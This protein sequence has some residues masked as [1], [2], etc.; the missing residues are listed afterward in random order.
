MQIEGL[1]PTETREVFRE[2]THAMENAAERWS[3]RAETGRTDDQLEQDIVF[4]VGTGGRTCRKTRHLVDYTSGAIRA[5]RSWQE[6]KACNPLSPRAAIPL[7][8]DLYGI[9]DP[10]NPQQSLF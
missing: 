10:S 2:A 7:A 5:G 4:E 6:L 3:E 8:R 1:S 9:A